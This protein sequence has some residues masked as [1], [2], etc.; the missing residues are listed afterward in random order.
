MYVVELAGVAG[1]GGA[2]V[3]TVGADDR[4]SEGTNVGNSDGKMGVGW[5]E[6]EIEL[7]LP[8]DSVG[9]DED[10]VI[11]AATD[12]TLDGRDGIEGKLEGGI[13]GRGVGEVVSCV[14]NAGVGTDVGVA[15]TVSVKVAN[16]GKFIEIS[17][18]VI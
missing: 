15:L 16:T 14:G 7:G 1:E 12:G 11:D 13:E 9:V 6:G 18:M 2:V 17:L 3:I 5:D 10:G 4:G 8:P